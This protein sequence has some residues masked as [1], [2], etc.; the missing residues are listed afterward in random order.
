MDRFIEAARRNNC[1][2]CNNC[3]TLV[4]IHRFAGSDGEHY[5]YYCIYTC[6]TPVERDWATEE[7][8][9]DE[10]LNVERFFSARIIHSPSPPSSIN[11][12]T[13]TADN[14]SWQQESGDDNHPESP[15]DIPALVD[16]VIES[17][18]VGYIDNPPE[19]SNWAF[20]TTAGSLWEVLVDTEINLSDITCDVCHKCSPQIVAVY[21]NTDGGTRFIQFQQICCN[22]A[23]RHNAE[24]VADSSELDHMS[25]P[26]SKTEERD[27]EGADVLPDLIPITDGEEITSEQENIAENDPDE[28]S[29][30]EIDEEDDTHPDE[31]LECP[32]CHN[33][34]PTTEAAYYF[35][36]DGEVFYQERL[37]C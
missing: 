30:S 36:S 26:P 16:V 23:T 7:I 14:L 33:C 35:R 31:S 15:T 29:S 37:I 28:S 32:Y 17:E 6:Q 8:S 20:T 21:R 3:Q 5:Y 1:R 9:D 24:A 19:R 18:S 12:E 2:L 25:D 34:E 13:V 22:T 27:C 4:R 10:D 11:E